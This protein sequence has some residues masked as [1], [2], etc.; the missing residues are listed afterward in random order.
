MR[1]D[2]VGLVAVHGPGGTISGAALGG[3]RARDLTATEAAAL[4]TEVI[5]RIFVDQPEGRSPVASGPPAV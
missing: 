5:A 3:R 4:A 2:T 1:V